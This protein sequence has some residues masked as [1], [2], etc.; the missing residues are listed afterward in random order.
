MIRIKKQPI[1]RGIQTFTDYD[2]DIYQD[3]YYMVNRLKVVDGLRPNRWRAG[4]PIN[5]GMELSTAVL[6]NEIENG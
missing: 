1:S 6:Y 5:T 3:Y 2:C 4:V